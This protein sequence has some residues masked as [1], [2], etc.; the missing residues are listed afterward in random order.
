MQQKLKRYKLSSLYIFFCSLIS[1]IYMRIVP[2][3]RRYNLEAF[4]CHD[5]PKGQVIFAVNHSNIHDIPMMWSILKRHVFVL[6]GDEP[7]GDSN[8]IALSVNGVIWVKRDQRESK[9]DA[10]K[11]MFKL[12]KKGK[13]LLI[14]PEAT[15]NLT[16]EKPMLPLHWGIIE[17]A[18]KSSCP[19]VPITL[20][21]TGKKSCRYSVGKAIYTSDKDDKAEMI[22]KLRDEMATMRW[23]AWETFAQDKREN[24]TIED[25]YVYTK[26]RLEEYPKL[27][28]EF[29]KTT[30]LHRNG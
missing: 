18:Q 17:L 8:G 7:R 25:F 3:V 4:Q 23:S 13:S 5:I 19:I 14:F 24:I 30:I 2:M 26:E 29:E 10:K 9:N 1:P 6:A 12:L 22:T 20:E 27:D 16:S 21:Y 15:W 11:N 28:V